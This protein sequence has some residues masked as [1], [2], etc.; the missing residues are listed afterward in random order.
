MFQSSLPKRS[1][2]N[3]S[4]GKIIKPHGGEIEKMSSKSIWQ[5]HTFIAGVLVVI[6]VL[7]FLSII[8][9]GVQAI[10]TQGL[11]TWEAQLIG[12]LQLI[13][14]SA[15]VAV[16][17]AFAWTLFGYLR[18]KAGDAAVQYDLTKL[19]QTVSWFLAF[20]LP[21]TYATSLPLATLTTV[22][23]VGAKAVLNQFLELMSQPAPT[24]SAVS[25]APPAG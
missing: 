21:L 3:K 25:P 10:S 19:S 5:N 23:I 22:L 15:P 24:S 12:V 11:P 9:P 17:A 7:G 18:Y 20:I 6:F 1:G 14:N 8:A 4:R 13:L 16:L 2:G